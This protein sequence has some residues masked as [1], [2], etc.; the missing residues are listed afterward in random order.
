MKI[1][2]DILSGSLSDKVIEASAVEVISYEKNGE[3]GDKI[4]D[5]LIIPVMQGAMPVA[6]VGDMG[7]LIDKVDDILDLIYFLAL[8]LARAYKVDVS[9]KNVVAEMYKKFT[10]MSL[11]AAKALEALKE[12]FESAFKDYKKVQDLD[13]QIDVYEDKVD[14]FKII[15]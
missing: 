1:I 13:S 6:L 9:K 4:A 11:L 14:E 3:N 15:Y 8:E 12:Q 10:G 7:L 5:K 2:N